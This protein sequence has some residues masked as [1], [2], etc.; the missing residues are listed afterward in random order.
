MGTVNLLREVFHVLYGV[1]VLN[2]SSAIL[3]ASGVELTGRSTRSHCYHPIDVPVASSEAGH[4]RPLEFDGAKHALLQEE[5]KVRTAVGYG[6]RLRHCPYS[7]GPVPT[8]SVLS[9]LPRSCP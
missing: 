2:L 3:Q 5:L 4:L 6:S 8:P 7:L 9:L 1:L